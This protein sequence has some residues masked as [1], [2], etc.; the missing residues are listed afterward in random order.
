MEKHI[1][2]IS[3]KVSKAIGVVYRLKHAYPETMMLILCH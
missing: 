3:K 2:H 1:D